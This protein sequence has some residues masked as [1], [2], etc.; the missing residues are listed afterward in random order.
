VKNEIKQTKEHL[1]MSTNGTTNREKYMIIF[2]M[3]LAGELMAQGFHLI[4]MRPD[5]HEPTKRVYIFNNTPDLQNA[6]YRYRNKK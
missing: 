6:I 2:S 3:K 4:N 5:V 1:T